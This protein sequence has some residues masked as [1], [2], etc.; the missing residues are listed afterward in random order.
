M[1]QTLGLSLAQEGPEASGGGKTENLYNHLNKSR[2]TKRCESPHRHAFWHGPV[3]RSLHRWTHSSQQR[4]HTDLQRSVL[5]LR[6]SLS[7]VWHLGFIESVCVCSGELF[8]SVEPVSHSVGSP[9]RITETLGIPSPIDTA[10]TRTDCNR[11]T[12]IIKVLIHNLINICQPFWNVCIIFLV[13]Q[14]NL[15]L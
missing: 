5:L 1:L 3:Q 9:Q 10:F 11:N 2:K 7:C 8:W 13:D 14:K 6:T 12:Y 15:V 4:D